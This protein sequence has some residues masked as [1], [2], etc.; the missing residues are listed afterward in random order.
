MSDATDDGA[1]FCT[2]PTAGEVYCASPAAIVAAAAAYPG[3]DAG[4]LAEA[5]IAAHHPRLGVE[6]SV[7]LRDLGDVA[8]CERCGRVQAEPNWCQR[9]GHRTS[10][11]EWA[12]RMFGEWRAAA[13]LEAQEALVGDGHDEAA[14]FLAAWDGGAGRAAVTDTGSS[15]T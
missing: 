13:L 12:T 8:V 5:L 1:V 10:T 7:C 6:R 14:A 9:C 11:P 15:S 4:L 2:S 3:N